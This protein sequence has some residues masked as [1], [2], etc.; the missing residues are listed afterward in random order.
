MDILLSEL[1]LLDKLQDDIRGRIEA[2]D[3]FCD[4]PVLAQ[5]KGVIASDIAEALATMTAKAGKSGAAVIVMMPERSTP[6]PNIPGPDYELTITVRAMELPLFNRGE[7]GTNKT[8]TA[9]SLRIEH[10]LHQLELDG[11]MLKASRAGGVQEESG[12]MAVDVQ[13]AFDFGLSA[14]KRVQAPGIVV[15]DGQATLTCGTSGATIRYTLDGTYPGLE[16][17][18]YAAPIVLTSSLTI[19]AAAYA[20]GYQSSSVSESTYTAP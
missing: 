19:R 20:S 1:T 3:Y 17:Q 6:K 14:A 10:L 9:L 2:D 4:V 7:T 15:A 13:I 5:N 11:L 12:G 16:A 8:C 18:A